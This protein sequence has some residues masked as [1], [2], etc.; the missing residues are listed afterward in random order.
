MSIA[1]QHNV[2][3][4]HPKQSS[5]PTQSLSKNSAINKRHLESCK[6]V[7]EDDD[8]YRR[9]PTIPIHS[10]RPY[11]TIQDNSASSRRSVAYPKLFKNPLGDG[12]CLPELER[13]TLEVGWCEV[14]Q[15]P[16]GD[17][18]THGAMF[19]SLPPLTS[20]RTCAGSFSAGQLAY[21]VL[22]TPPVHPY[23]RPHAVSRR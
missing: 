22:H 12:K 2:S 5:I 13:V 20:S 19:S 3:S 18:D 23:R 11:T 21:A 10:N 8:L 14:N 1:P 6:T 7:R 16:K 15:Q 17:G 4:N 9:Q